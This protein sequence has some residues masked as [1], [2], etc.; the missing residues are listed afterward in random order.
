MIVST[1]IKFSTFIVHWVRNWL[2]I[3]PIQ[4]DNNNNMGL[5]LMD[6][7]DSHVY[8]DNKYVKHISKVEKQIE[9][10]K[11]QLEDLKVKQKEYEI[12][13]KILKIESDKAFD[14]DYTSDE[15][16]E[17]DEWSVVGDVWL[18]FLHYL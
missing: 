12:F 17:D 16:G 8:K 13:K 2:P 11:S 14:G 4:L 6:F 7:V 18:V 10:L 15:S 1:V 3:R 9:L 5:Q